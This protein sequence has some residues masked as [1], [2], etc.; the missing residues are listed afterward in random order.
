MFLVSSLKDKLK[1]TMLEI[2]TDKTQICA[3]PYEKPKKNGAVIT[4][5]KHDPDRDFDTHKLNN[6]SKTDWERTFTLPKLRRKWKEELTVNFDPT[7]KKLP[8]DIISDQT[9]AAKQHIK[10]LIDPDILQIKDKKFNSSVNPQIC[11][12]PDLK[13]TLFEVSNGL[14][15]FQVVPLKHKKVEEGTDTR[16]TM[17]INGEKWNNSTLFENWEKKYIHASS[18]EAAMNN[19]VNYWRNTE[20]DRANEVELPITEGRKKLEMPRYYK[21]YKTPVQDAKYKYN[22][23]QRVREITWFERELMAKKIIHENPGCVKYPEKIRSIVDREMAAL[24]QEKYNELTGKTQPQGVVKDITAN[25]KRTSNSQGVKKNWKDKELTDKI[26]TL[27]EWEDIGWFK[28]LRTE[29]SVDDN[30]QRY[31]NTMYSSSKYNELQKELKRKQLLRPLV[32]KGTAILKEEEKIREKIADDVKK[33]IKMEMLQQRKHSILNNQV[34]D[35]VA[36]QQKNL[37]ISKYPL[38]K[39]TYEMLKEEEEQQRFMRDERRFTSRKEGGLNDEQG[40]VVHTEGNVVPVV[41]P[42]SKKYFL[43][44]YKTVALDDLKEQKMKK[45]NNNN[46]EFQYTHFGTYVSNICI[47]I[48]ICNVCYIERF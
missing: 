16:N 9:K 42:F 8:D 13:K 21:Q 47:Y 18:K 23:M 38:D 19:T 24:Y 35:S 41:Q 4:V 15:N 33:K 25:M 31:Y 27:N 40:I 17:Y 37:R 45:K 26:K 29:M 5:H 46:F 43:E 14:N 2:N 20:T 32:S 11:N 39:Q 34:V 7:H 30:C 22:T 36:E 44:A 48:C 6:L 3:F 1:R 28:P 12:Y 10:D